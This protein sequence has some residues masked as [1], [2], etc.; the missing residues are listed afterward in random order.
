MA[1]LIVKKIADE[2]ILKRESKIKLHMQSVVEKSIS[3]LKNEVEVIEF[4][5]LMMEAGDLYILNT[6]EHFIL[7]N[8]CLITGIDFISDGN[9]RAMV[10]QANKD[11]KSIIEYFSFGIE[12]GKYAE[13]AS[14]TFLDRKV[15]LSKK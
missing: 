15:R 4:E 1:K 2:S 12:L 13:I 8:E 11:N 7:K 9:A 6:A 10:L 5:R 14:K 3:H